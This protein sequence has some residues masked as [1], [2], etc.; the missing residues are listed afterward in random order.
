MYFHQIWK[1]K[2]TR[3]NILNITFSSLNIVFKNPDSYWNKPLRCPI[4]LNYKCIYIS[5]NRKEEY[6]RFKIKFK[7]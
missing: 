2:N 7:N 6:K 3:I 5:S 1:K 4:A